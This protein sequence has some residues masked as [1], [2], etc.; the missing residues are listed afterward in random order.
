MQ[1]NT[2]ANAFS[3]TQS[4]QGVYATYA[5]T[6]RFD[7]INVAAAVNSNMILPKGDG[8]VWNTAYNQWSG[9]NMA[10]VTFNAA[11]AVP[12]PTTATLSL[13]ALAGLAAR[14]RRR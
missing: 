10:A 2:T 7:K 12:E 3:T 8:I 1:P 13:L 14:R 11:P 4:N 9:Q 6:S 5:A